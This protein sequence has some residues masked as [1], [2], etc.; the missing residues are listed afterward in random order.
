MNPHNSIYNCII[1][2]DDNIDRLTTLSFV[3]KYPQIN[4]LGVY[5]SAAEAIQ[6]TDFKEVDILFTDIDMPEISGLEL[7]K[8]LTEIPACIFITAYPE[9]AS[10]SFD[11]D[12]L[13]FLVKPIRNER[14]QICISRIQK[15]FDLRKKA[16][17]FEHSLGGDTIFI[18]DGHEQIKVKL[19]EIVYLEAL[20]D[21]TRIVTNTKKYSVLISIG[22]LLVEPAFNSFVRIHRSYAVQLHF[23]DRI[24]TQQLHIQHYTLPIGRSYKEILNKES[25]FINLL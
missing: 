8:Q 23:V 22:N 24:S 10:E 12:A 2:D 15:Y 21:Y 19:H 18:K 5:E 13:D 11:V 25:K 6:N 4:I 16:K 1:I 17:L 7:R 3:K 20:K 9:Y 14:F